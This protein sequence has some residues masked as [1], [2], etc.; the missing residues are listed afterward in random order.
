MNTDSGKVKLA[1]K[2]FTVTI[3][4]NHVAEIFL[5]RPNSMNNGFWREL[6]S[7]VNKL[8]MII[9]RAAHLIQIRLMLRWSCILTVTLLLMDCVHFN[10]K[11]SPI[12]SGLYP[13]NK[14][15]RK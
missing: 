9:H 7:I 6:P 4:D 1:L 14:G 13:L 3:H 12:A 8:D 5:D 2:A 11:P 10:L 15:I